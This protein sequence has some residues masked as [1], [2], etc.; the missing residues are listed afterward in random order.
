MPY[1]HNK[2]AIDQIARYPV[3][4][5]RA[6]CHAVMASITQS[7]IRCRMTVCNGFNQG[8]NENEVDITMYSQRL[9]PARPILMGP[10]NDLY[11]SNTYSVIYVIFM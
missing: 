10:G 4:K 11:T 9:K 8:N 2:S 1:P 7:Q 5:F 3:C 6:E